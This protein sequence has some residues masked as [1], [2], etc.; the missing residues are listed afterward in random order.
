M[1]MAR[2]PDLGWAGAGVLIAVA[3]VSLSQAAT[4][5]DPTPVRAQP[6]PLV[7]TTPARPTARVP[8][9]AAPAQEAVVPPG[10][11][12]VRV[13]ILMYH[14]IRVNPDPRDKLGFNLS[15]TPG[16]FTR[17]MDWLAENGYH[18]VDLSDL[19][20]YLL[21]H[22]A[23]PSKPIVLTFD[24]G[25]RDVYTTAFPVL[26][27][28]HFK[29]V[30]YIVSG[31]VNSPNNVTGEQVLEMDANG[32]EI[33]VHTVSHADLTRLAG[34]D[35][36]REVFDSKAW[37]EGLLGHPVHD[38][39]YPSGRFNGAVVAAVQAAGFESATTTEP[40]T[41]H[42]AGD[43]FTWTR[44]RVSGG[45]SLDQLIADLGPPEGT[46]M[47]AQAQPRAVPREGLARLPITFPIRP[48]PEALS[49]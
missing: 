31:F 42:S 32:V 5:H 30:A 7:H 9:A 34:G 19:R 44:V 8:A 3:A 21:G 25:Y 38:F 13:P 43:R 33:G 24:D 46:Q 27:A 22:A 15:V 26:R 35:L 4:L 47:M 39:C 11:P 36:H 18:P 49:E 2:R 17:Q 37:L 20:A 29:G 6:F 16:D 23:L 40:G 45:E 12:T 28:H 48:P 41:V 10:R 1:T 14:Y